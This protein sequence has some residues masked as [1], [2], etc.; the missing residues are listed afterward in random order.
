MG[1]PAN[2]I[3][4]ESTTK[5]IQSIGRNVHLSVVTC[6]TG[7]L[8]LKKVQPE[9]TFFKRLDDLWVLTNFLGFGVNRLVSVFDCETSTPSKADSCLCIK[10]KAQYFSCI[11]LVL[12][13]ATQLQFP[14]R[15]I[16]C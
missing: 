12:Y 9:K 1:G 4:N 8:L 5:P 13:V 11:I 2:Y 3:F 7:D 10:K 14:F 6:V 15:V 16:F